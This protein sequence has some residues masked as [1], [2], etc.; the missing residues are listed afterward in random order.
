M[1][2]GQHG[3]RRVFGGG[4]AVGDAG[5]SSAER[6]DVCNADGADKGVDLDSLAGMV[7]ERSR[8]AG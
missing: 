8:M 1:K 5:E 4:N 3:R 6:N 2:Y 7:F